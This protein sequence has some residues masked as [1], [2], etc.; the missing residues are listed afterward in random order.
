MQHAYLYRF[1]YFL[2]NRTL[3]IAC[4]IDA[5]SSS[6]FFFSTQTNCTNRR[7]I[8]FDMFRF[9]RRIGNLKTHARRTRWLCMFLNSSFFSRNLNLRNAYGTSKIASSNFGN[10]KHYRE[11]NFDKRIALTAYAFHLTCSDFLAE[12]KITKR[13]REA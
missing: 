11:N 5:S 4:T 8:S 12:S 10:R 2:R 9:S 7:S 6:R 13:M 3:G 1:S